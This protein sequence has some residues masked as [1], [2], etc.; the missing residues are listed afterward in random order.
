VLFIKF[1]FY[2]ATVYNRFFKNLTIILF[3]TN[4]LFFT[5]YVYSFAMAYASPQS[6][7]LQ[8]LTQSQVPCDASLVNV[9][10]VIVIYLCYFVGAI[11][12]KVL[13]DRF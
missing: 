4:F 2:A 3:F 12:T 11:C 1:N 5:Y 7:T 9:V 13:G 6:K 8:L 10:G